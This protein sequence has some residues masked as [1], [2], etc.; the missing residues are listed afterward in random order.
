MAMDCTRGDALG[1]KWWFCK[2]QFAFRMDPVP[3]TSKRRYRFLRYRNT[4]GHRQRRMDSAQWL[5]WQ[6]DTEKPIRYR[7][8]KAQELWDSD[9]WGEY[10]RRN[11]NTSWKQRKKRRQWA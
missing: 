7:N 11:C 4:T 5:P 9:Y 10:P 8:A 1:L 6:S 2:H 3:W